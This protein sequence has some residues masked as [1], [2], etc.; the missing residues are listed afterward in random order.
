MPTDDP[1]SLEP[2]ATPPID[3]EEAAY[4][5]RR[6]EEELEM[7]QKATRPEVVAAHVALADAYLAR[8]HAPASRVEGE[9]GSGKEDKDA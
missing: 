5:Q 4:L 2:P 3:E 9:P 8:L 6:A 7:A 1:H